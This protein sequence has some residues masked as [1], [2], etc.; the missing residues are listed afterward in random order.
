MKQL[1]AYLFGAAVASSVFLGIYVHKLYFVP[2][3]FFR[4]SFFTLCSKLYC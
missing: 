3:V 1:V 4:F 2:T